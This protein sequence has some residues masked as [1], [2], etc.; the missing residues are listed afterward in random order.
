MV[1]SR[2]NRQVQYYEIKLKNFFFDV[3]KFSF[4]LALLLILYCI[5]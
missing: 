2:I 3:E 1:V 4:P 5:S